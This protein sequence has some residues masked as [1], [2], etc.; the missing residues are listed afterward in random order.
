MDLPW[1]TVKNCMRYSFICFIRD[2]IIAISQEILYDYVLLFGQTSVIYKA[3]EG[4]NPL[5]L[6]NWLHCI[7]TLRK[8]YDPFSHMK[9]ARL[10]GSSI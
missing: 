6:L 10:M 3:C 5:Y 7:Q 1:L 4:H 2:I 8:S 9:P